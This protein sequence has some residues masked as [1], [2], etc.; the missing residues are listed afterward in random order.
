MAR[1]R[2]E[3]G[4]GNESNICQICVFKDGKCVF[5]ECRHG[6]R[7]DDTVHV[8][9][10]TKGVM[11]LLAGIALDAGAIASVGEK[12]LDFFP[13]YEPPRGEKTAR[14]VEIRHLL[15]MTAPWKFRSDPWKKVYT[16]PDWT[17]AVLAFL[18][19]RKGLTGAFR[20]TTLGLQAL[21]GVLEN[22]TGTRC[23]DFANERL[24]APLGIAPRK[25]HGDSSQEDQFRFAMD[26]APKGQEWYCDP[27]G[28]ATAG[29]G[30]ALSAREMAAI[31]EMCRCRGEYRG[32][33]VVSAGWIR[34]MAA[35]RVELGRAFGNMAYGY[36]WYRPRRDGPVFAAMGDGGNLIYVNEET[37]I[38]AG[39]TG[40][41]RPRVFD[42]IEYLE[43][44]ILPA[45]L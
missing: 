38:A 1:K 44:E 37:G 25:P 19:G 30:L 13:G 9:S 21:G 3:P 41:F 4:T 24:F 5:D 43:R 16:S 28:A 20:Y 15:T 23:L 35:P 22:A 27:A 39:V 42:R 34:E 2:T 14:A 45:F 32:K 7:P 10:V 17:E 36:L 12:V 33:R 40:T 31:G 29:W 18:G 8:M 6:Y 11:A 26:K